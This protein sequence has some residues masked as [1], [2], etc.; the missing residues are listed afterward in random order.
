MSYTVLRVVEAGVVLFDAHRS[1][2]GTTAEAAFNAFARGAPPGIFALH[3]AGG[4]L[5]VTA[6]AASR[7]ADGIPL[8]TARTPLT[9][10][11]VSKPAP[12]SDYDRVR[13]PG[14]ATL[15]LDA[16]GN[17]CEACSA[18]VLACNGEAIIAVP[19]GFP[20]VHSSAEEALLRA[21]PHRFEPFPADTALPLCLVNAVV[22]VCVPARPGPAFPPT[23]R[24]R[25][26]EVLTA[27]A[28]RPT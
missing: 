4:T 1:R 12:P 14:V 20:R 28:R 18:A 8:R 27:T 2:L 16:A 10:G 23:W 19:R 9:G 6:R 11:P 22:G 17:V 24:T 15:L 21:L 5:Q 25:M 26:M 13:A 7:L 3:W